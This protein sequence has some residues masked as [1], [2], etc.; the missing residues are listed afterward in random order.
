[1]DITTLRYEVRNGGGGLRST[2]TTWPF[3]GCS[4]LSKG[5]MRMTKVRAGA[6]TGPSRSHKLTL[7]RDTREKISWFR[8]PDQLS[9]KE[10]LVF[11]AGVLG[12]IGGFHD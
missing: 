4:G 3:I 12:V 2:P 8:R 6:A 9:G 5:R 10:T 1:M 7:R 11:T